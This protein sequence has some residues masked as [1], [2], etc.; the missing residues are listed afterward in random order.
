VSSSDRTTTASIIVVTR[1]NADLLRE[2]LESILADTSRVPRELIVVDNGSTDRTADIVAHAAVMASLPVTHL[3]E[4]RVGLSRGRNAGVAAAHGEVLLF[5]DDDVLVEDGWADALVAPFADPSVAVVGGRTL[6]VWP[7]PPPHWLEGPQRGRLE[8]LDLG[9]EDRFLDDPA[10][11]PVGANVAIRASV[12][13]EL[14]GPFD[15]SLGN[16]GNRRFGR[17]E[18]VVIRRLRES[19]RVAY[20]AGAVVQH[21]IRPERMTLH[22]LRGTYFDMGAGFLRADLL[23]ATADLPSWPRRVVRALRICLTVR[24]MRD[25]SPDSE[26]TAATT[27]EELQGYFW[28]GRHVEMV[29]GRFPRLAGKVR[30]AVS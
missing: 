17:E 30:D 19:H 5:T 18:A 14:E 12:L 11:S 23:T 21:R 20:A 10:E 22:W 13:S 8:L 7:A 25:G 6:P 28:A 29:L 27:T 9:D 4:P 24:R 2:A 15:V 3:A 1:N 26:R 16:T